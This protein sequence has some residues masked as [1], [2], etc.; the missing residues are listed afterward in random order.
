MLEVAL[1]VELFESGL[2][3]PSRLSNSGIGTSVDRRS[4]VSFAVVFWLTSLFLLN[5]ITSKLK[6]TDLNRSTVLWSRSFGILS[7]KG[8]VIDVEAVPQL[9]L[10]ETLLN[11]SADES[12]E[13]ACCT[14]VA[15]VVSSV[16]I[17]SEDMIL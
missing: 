6:S 10:V 2:E 11:A 17:S 16:A 7:R 5:N 9:G 8:R 4:E 15:D 3:G 12:D 14:M 13:C 1:G